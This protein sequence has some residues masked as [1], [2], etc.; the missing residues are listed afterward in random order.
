LRNSYEGELVVAGRADR[1]DVAAP[2]VEPHVQGEEIM[3]E[4]LLVILD[5]QDSEENTAA[6]VVDEGATPDLGEST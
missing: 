6:G 3:E 5:L 1:A 4:N 2:L